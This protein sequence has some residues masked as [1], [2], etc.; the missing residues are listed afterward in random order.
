MPDAGICTLRIFLSSPGDV[1]AERDVADRILSEIERSPAWRGRFRFEIVRW[2]DPHA[3]VPMDAHFPPQEAINRHL[4]KPSQCDIVIVILWSR[5]GT[6]LGEPKKPDGSPYLSGTEWEFEDGLKGQGR[7]LLF[8]GLHKPVVEL[9]DPKYEER[10]LQYQ[11][12]QRFFDSFKRPDGSLIHSVIAYEAPGAF[13]RTFQQAMEGVLRVIADAAYAEQLREQPPERLRPCPAVPP[14]PDRPYPLLQPHTLLR[15]VFRPLIDDLTTLF[16]GRGR[17]MDELARLVADP[18]V[19]YVVIT[20]PAGFGK[21]ALVAGFLSEADVSASYHFFAPNQIPDSDSEEFFLTN[22]VQQ[23]AYE[24]GIRLELPVRLP[25]L[26]ATYYELL[27]APSEQ[28]RLLLLDGVDEVTSWRV[29][30]Y[31]GQRLPPQQHVVLT[32]RDVGQDWTQE[33]RL[34]NDATY[35]FS[36]SGLSVRG[37]ADILHHAG[38]KA[39]DLAANDTALRELARATQFEPDPQLGIDPLYARVAIED[40]AAGVMTVESLRDDPRG[41]TNYLNKWWN[42]LTDTAGEGTVGEVLGVLTVALGRLSH[43][44]LERMVPSLGQGWAGDTFTREILPKIRRF[45]VG[46]ERDGYALMHPRFR[47]FVQTQL[48]TLGAYRQRIIKFCSEG[49]SEGNRYALANYARHLYEAG[50]DDNESDDLFHL[51]EYRGWHDARVAAEP[52][53]RGFLDDIGLAWALAATRDSAAVDRGDRCEFLAR[54]V[55]GALATS[56]VRSLSRNIPSQLLSA[57]VAADI[58]RPKEALALVRLNVDARGR[59]ASL[60]AL[61]P[62]LDGVSLAEALAVARTVGDSKDCAVCLAKLSLAVPEGDRAGVLNE[63]IDFAHRTDDDESRIQA[64]IEVAQASAEPQRAALLDSALRATERVA[65]SLEKSHLQLSLIP[66]LT[67]GDKS[68]VLDEIMAAM[69]Q[70]LDDRW[71][72]PYQWVSDSAE[73]LAEVTRPEDYVLFREALEAVNDVED[74]YEKAFCKVKLASLAS[75]DDVRYS[76][77]REALDVTNE[78]DDSQA[79]QRIIAQIIEDVRAREHDSPLSLGGLVDDLLSAAERVHDP[80]AQALALAV[81]VNVVPEPRRFQLLDRALAAARVMPSPA[82]RAERLC[83]LGLVLPPSERQSTL[84]DALEA[85]RNVEPVPA[86]VRVMATVSLHLDDVQRSEVL[87]ELFRTPGAMEAIISIEPDE[88]EFVEALAPLLRDLGA[89]A[90]GT[91]IARALAVARS[92]DN[93]YERA[94]SLLALLPHCPIEHRLDV[95]H[96]VQDAAGSIV[97]VANRAEVRIAL[98]PYVLSD[99]LKQAVDEARAD[100]NLIDEG[101]ER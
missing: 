64:L 26:R 48:R 38:G 6:P 23:L 44:D 82:G 65:P 85:A 101:H 74:A 35:Y 10:R 57:L 20:A 55:R 28:N 45:V 83:Q 22:V 41:L 58:V 63:A 14:L 77:L 15:T 61:R 9:D 34:P 30:P 2:D 32:L 69:L 94:R 99:D 46:N 78:S 93:S 25:D 40:I 71:L 50:I 33:F 49:Y 29:A 47:D 4:P 53:R 51:V 5:M 11:T 43:D 66:L 96:Q 79:I 8:R 39:R 60:I 16:A 24:Q 27:A 67:A 52:T 21:S 42:S 87:K 7:V 98:V 81:L 12:V 97:D 3:A 17:E 19:Q 95:V 70:S 54:E 88:L 92:I 89:Q 100:V 1:T 84:E 18:N 37:L 72:R 91:T 31:I 62:Y 76:L 90:D 86:R 75:H 13:G 56:S 80:D 36:L 59:A 73:V 68:R